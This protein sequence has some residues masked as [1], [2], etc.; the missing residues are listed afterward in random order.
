MKRLSGTSGVWDYT[1]FEYW[2]FETND[3]CHPDLVGYYRRPSETGLCEG[4]T[5]WGAP[6]ARYYEECPGHTGGPCP[7]PTQL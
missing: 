1:H 7:H 4:S 3:S 5:L 2:Y 6:L